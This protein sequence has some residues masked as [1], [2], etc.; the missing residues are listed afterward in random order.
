MGYQNCTPIQEQAIPLIL[1]GKDLIG[2]AQ[3]GTGKTAAFVVPLLQKIQQKPSDFI[4]ALI[5]VPTR[6]LAK[7]IDELI[8]GIAYHSPVR[9]VAIYGGGKGE[10]F[11]FQQNAIKKG[12]D[13]LIATPG[14]L[15]AH[16]QLGYV[17]FD[18][19][20]FLVLDEADKMLDMGFYEDIKF[21]VHKLNPNRQTLLFSATMPTNIRKLAQEILKNPEEISISVSMPADKIRQQI[22]WVYDHQ[23]LSALEQIFKEKTVGTMVLFTSRKRFV[24]D[25]VRSLAKLGFSVEGMHSDKE[26]EER[27]RIMNGFRHHQFQILVAT[28]IV[29]R[30]I[31]VEGITHVVN[32]DVPN[33]PEDYVHRI[34]RT[35]R[36]EAEGEAYTFV[37]P[38]DAFRLKRIEKLIGKEIPKMTLPPE[39]G[40][41]P[42]P[43]TVSHHPDHNKNHKKGKKKNTS[44]SNSSSATNSA[45]G[46]KSQGGHKKSNHFK[47]KPDHPSANANSITESI[48]PDTP[49]PL[50]KA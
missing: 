23:K 42:D 5:I 21:I 37:T 25:I 19:L 34:G 50:P 47:K 48:S 30:G 38:E 40:E 24:N 13:I 28:D 7:Q 6:E 4:R 45:S 22:V 8:D 2:C 46:D 39:V 3:T 1:S 16:I 18:Q 10:D 29:S 9:S 20:E 17:K 41:T 27:E 35:A 26:Q 43:N 15:M 11:T 12:A 49:T 33:D 31:D 14:R 36:A 44:S 32:F